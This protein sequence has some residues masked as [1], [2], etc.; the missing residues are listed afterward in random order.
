MI[1]HNSAAV[2]WDN[3]I[4]VCNVCLCHHNNILIMVN[5]NTII[6]Y[7]IFLKSRDLDVDKVS[8]LILQYHS[9]YKTLIRQITCQHV[10]KCTH[11]S[12]V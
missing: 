8:I 7:Y 10:V 1:A 3:K 11:M 2:T 5:N 6:L 9:T 4:V 12:N